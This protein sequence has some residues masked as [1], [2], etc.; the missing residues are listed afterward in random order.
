[1]GLNCARTPYAVGMSENITIYTTPH[2]PGCALTQRKLDKAGITYTAIDLSK[3][4]DLVEQFKNEGL[5]SAPIIET[6]T[7]RSSGFNPERIR[8][9]I[10]LATP[11]TK[12]DQAGHA[13]TGHSSVTSSPSHPR[14]LDHGV[15]DEHGQGR[16]L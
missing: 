5:L 3:R 10:A 7:G 8:V 11:Y 14:N 13:N 9:I 4:P 12:P 1:M 15:T 2:C 6:Q 16:G